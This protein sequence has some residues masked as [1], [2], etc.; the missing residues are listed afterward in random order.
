VE[1]QRRRD[2]QQ[3]EGQQDDD[4]EAPMPN[5]DDTDETDRDEA[6]DAL[7]G[8]SGARSLGG[9]RRRSEGNMPL[10][11]TGGWF[12]LRWWKNRWKWEGEQRRE[13]DG[14]EGV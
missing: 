7:L 11:A 14:G 3:Q 10:A 2:V 1:W 12:K 9:M 13:G 6:G 5:D 8:R 4:D